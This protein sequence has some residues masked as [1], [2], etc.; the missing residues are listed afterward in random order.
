MSEQQ[1]RWSG[2]NVA[3]RY[4]LGSYL[5]GTEHGSV[6]ATEIVHARAQKVA[7][8]LI[9]AAALDAERQ[10][11]RWKRAAALSHANLLKILDYGKC[12]LDGAGYLF[13]VTEFADEDLGDILPE[14]A[15]NADETRGMIEP[16]VETLA[17]LHQQGWVHT[18]VH[19]GNILAMGDQIKLSSDSITPKDEM[20][21]VAA[22]AEGF[23]AP[24]FGSIAVAAGQDIWSLGASIVA[25][26][27]QRPPVFRE[28]GGL[29]LAAEIPEPL[30]GIAREA[31]Q[32]DATQRI[33]IAGIRAKLN[34]ASVPPV[35]AKE[36]AKQPEK[37][38]ERIAPKIDPVKVPLSPVAPPA[39]SELRAPIPARPPIRVQ[40]GK[41]RSYWMP[42]GAALVV[43]VIVFAWPKLNRQQSDADTTRPA[44]SPAP[45]A[46]TTTPSVAASSREPVPASKRRAEAANAEI[47]PAAARSESVPH[48]KSES[49]TD[50]PATKGDVMDQV[51]P[52][53]SDKARA[54]IQG[55]VRISIRVH[56]N[57]AGTVDTAEVDTP[58]GSKY[59]AEQAIKAA[60]KWQFTAPEISGRSVES[61]WLLHFEITSTAT[62]VS[63]KQVSP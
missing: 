59:F 36:P 44:S 47:A 54:T 49:K 34:P 17:F 10:L 3:G 41:K 40:G 33:S 39:M 14:R 52:D 62:N 7:I 60:K 4:P 13:V 6:F 58:S 53:V 16:V 46:K 24:E 63:S 35:V 1:H 25:A 22:K 45:S 26:M 43:A 61:D 56:V 29:E 57:A 30:A 28:D 12:E 42:I 18:R 21:G 8:K 11:A 9:P 2:Q 48:S 50:G 37:K 20:A 15:L 19:P 5:G 27:T 51:L 38:P 31:L 55:R 32:A 23:A